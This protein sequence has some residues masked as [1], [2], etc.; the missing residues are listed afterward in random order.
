[1]YSLVNTSNRERNFKDGRITGISWAFISPLKTNGTF[2]RYYTSKI[3][4][5]VSNDTVKPAFL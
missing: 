3:S 1:M 4:I 5:S 2:L